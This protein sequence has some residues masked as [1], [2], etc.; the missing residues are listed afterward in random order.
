VSVAAGQPWL[1]LLPP[2]HCQCQRAIAPRRNLLREISSRICQPCPIGDGSV[3]LTVVASNKHSST[4]CP[5]DQLL[6]VTGTIYQP[7]I[8]DDTGPQRRNRVAVKLDCCRQYRRPGKWLKVLPVKVSTL[9]LIQSRSPPAN[10]RKG[11]IAERSWATT[12]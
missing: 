11:K 12:G 1:L 6:D 5:A 10:C 4:T 2:A 7:A 9:R 8:A 3:T